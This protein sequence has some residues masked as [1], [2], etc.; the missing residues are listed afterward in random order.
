[1]YM[2]VYVCVCMYV[3]KCVC[4]CM[5]IYIYIYSNPMHVALPSFLV[6][7]PARQQA[8]RQP[9]AFSHLPFNQPIQTSHSHLER[10]I[11]TPDPFF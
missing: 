1:M 3:Y 9:V 6:V 8:L 10:T 11:H 4:V 2:C 7:G 5:C